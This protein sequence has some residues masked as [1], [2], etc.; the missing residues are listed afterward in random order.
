MKNFGKIKS[1]ILQKLI[2][3]YSSQKKSE[4]KDILN[5][6]KENKDFKEMYVLYEDMENK[7]FEDKDVAKLYVEELTSILKT[8]SGNVSKVCSK[9]DKILGSIEVNENELYKNLDI[10]SESDSLLNIDKK[11]LA[12]KNLVGHLTKKKETIVS[13]N[14]TY[15]Q[16]ENLL[17]VVLTNNFNTLYENTLN[18]DEKSELK[19]ILSLSNS[20]TE[21]KMKEL[22]EDVQT[23]I[24]ELMLET[25]DE[26]LTQK[27]KDVLSEMD[28]MNVSKLNYYRLSQ[29]K[30]GL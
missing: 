12:K 1:K 21:I 15:T 23:K 19:N 22:K 25:K 13:E 9:I 17:Y 20:E 3:S 18:E 5:L 16:N 27:L 26:T 24:N 11:V 10:L 30:N 6:I 4:V 14:T 7:Y 28:E 2:E 29:L 8:K